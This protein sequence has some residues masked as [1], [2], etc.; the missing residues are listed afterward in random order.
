MIRRQTSEAFLLDEEHEEHSQTYHSFRV[1]PRPKWVIL[2]DP[3]PRR[4]PTRPWSRF[5]VA[6]DIRTALTERSS[7]EELFQK[8]A[9]KVDQRI[10]MDR[11]ILGGA[12]CIAGTRIPVYAILQLVEAG[13]SHKR[14]LKSFPSL[15][16]ADLEAALRFSA[17]VMER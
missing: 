12:P 1:G 10:Q 7:E 9:E 5:S 3:A 4:F 2:E 13:Y 14:I 17:I 11:K 8:A 6:S 16:A 15:S